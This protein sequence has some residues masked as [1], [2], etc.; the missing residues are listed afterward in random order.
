MELSK[1]IYILRKEQR[2]SQEELAMQINVSRQAVSKWESGQAIPDT[3]NIILLSKILNVSTDYLLNDESE[4]SEQSL[5][6]S[7]EKS[8]LLIIGMI[9]CALGFLGAAICAAI[10]LLNSSVASQDMETIS[11]NI[12]GYFIAAL[13]S[14]MVFVIGAGIL[15]ILIIKNK[16]R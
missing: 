12:N 13:L 16:R 4:L 6:P 8:H 1:K 3:N 10:I 2:L 7:H 11:F 5:I 14:A 15:T 9:I